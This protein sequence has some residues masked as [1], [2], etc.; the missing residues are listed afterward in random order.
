MVVGSENQNCRCNKTSKEMSQQAAKDRES[1]KHKVGSN[2][3]MFEEIEE[4]E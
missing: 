3:S 4:E 1:M 2:N